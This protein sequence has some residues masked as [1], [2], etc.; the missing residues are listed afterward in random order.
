MR[1]QCQKQPIHL[2]QGELQGESL[3]SN[4]FSNAIDPSGTARVGDMLMGSLLNGMLRTSTQWKG[5]FSEADK[6][7]H[8]IGVEPM[9]SDRALAQ[10]VFDP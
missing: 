10:A 3:R 8:F 5:I 4:T 9:D 7:Y 1:D 6:R 2:G